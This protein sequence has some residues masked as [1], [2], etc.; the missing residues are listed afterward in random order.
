M[1]PGIST[2]LLDLGRG[3]LG[4]EQCVIDATGEPISRP[5][6]TLS[7]WA[8]GASGG[9]PLPIGS[10]VRRRIGPRQLLGDLPGNR[11]Q[12]KTHKGPPC[13]GSPGE[14]SSPPLEIIARVCT[15]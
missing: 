13:A 15:G 3:R 8:I 2:E 10:S 7:G 4:P 6:A 12:I 14:S 5:A 11:P 1:L 9:W